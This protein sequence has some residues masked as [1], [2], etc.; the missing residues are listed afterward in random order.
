[1]SRTL[2]SLFALAGLAAPALADVPPPPGV[3]EKAYAEQIVAAGYACAEPVTYKALTGKRAREL[4]EKG[5]YAF[6]VACKGGKS[7][8]VAN[9]PR[10]R[11][12]VRPSGDVPVKPRP[13]PI[14]EPMR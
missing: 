12:W 2:L 8:L 10:P 4:E 9:P 1:M 11:P 5:L 7:Y 6:R 13:L 14:V 3:R